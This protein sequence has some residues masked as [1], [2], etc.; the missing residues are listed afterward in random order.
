MKFNYSYQSQKLGL[1]WLPGASEHGARF[2][3]RYYAVRIRGA[4]TGE[5]NFDID[6]R[7]V[8]ALIAKAGRKIWVH[9]DGKTYNL[10]RLVGTADQAGLAS[11]ERILRAPM[12]GQVRQVAVKAGQDVEAGEVLVLLEAM[13]MEIRIHSPQTAKVARV[14]VI[15]GQN[16]EREQILVE[17]EG[18]DG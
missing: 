8:K 6:G 11:G 3:G 10:E 7:N 16:V 5:L 15:E 12:P 9:L 13:K 1:E 2:G 4:G 14:A 17:L 18:E